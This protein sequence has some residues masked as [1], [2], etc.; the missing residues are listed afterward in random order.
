MND[1]SCSN[2]VR[3][4]ALM[5]GSAAVSWLQGCAGTEPPP[6][7][8]VAGS[9]GFVQGF[10]VAMLQSPVPQ[11]ADLTTPEVADLV[12]RAI[13]QAGG[14]DFI[15]DGQ[16][17]V[18]KPNLP[19]VYQDNGETLANPRVSG[20]NTD[21]RVS[22]AVADLVR[23]R[24][25]T[26]KI[27]VMEGSTFATSIAYAAL[28]Y[29]SQNFG[30]SVDEFIAL[31]GASCTETSTEPLEQRTAPSGKQ[32]WINRRYAAADVVIAVSTLATDAW[33]GIG[34]AVESLGIG[35]TPAG[36]YSSGDNPNDC[37]R[38]KIDRSTPETVGA[39]IRDYYAIKP[40]DFV[41]VDALQGLE[42]GPLPVLEQS[43]LDYASSTKNMRLVMAGRNAI[44]V[45]TVLA[46]VMKCSPKRVPHLLELEGDGR[47]TTD[48]SK[49]NLVGTQVADVAKPFASKQTEICPGK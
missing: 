1:R 44:A 29:T 32:Y 12:G 25:P 2:A 48:I 31:E 41:V 15:K 5:W 19:T 14:L 45:D 21:W 23:A 18:L 30:A 46:L 16:T 36:Q 43:T 42:H 8:A 37:T 4:V 34:G 39:F 33:A 6:A 7:A 38:A 9:P 27:F 11:A 35:A 13:T 26:G 49:I 40:A 17:V 28:G 47:G 20:I 10:T 3:F 22:K 24:N